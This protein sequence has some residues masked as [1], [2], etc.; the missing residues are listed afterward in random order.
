M[1]DRDENKKG[2]HWY[3]WDLHG[4]HQ[5]WRTRRI[6]EFYKYIETIGLEKAWIQYIIHDIEDVIQVEGPELLMKSLD[7]SSKKKLIDYIKRHY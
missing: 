3:P 2:T 4:T 7:I 5:S 1:S 6:D